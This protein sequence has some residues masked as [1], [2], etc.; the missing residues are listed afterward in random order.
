MSVRGMALARSLVAA[1]AQFD[2]Q[3]DLF[4]IPVSGLPA[5]ESELVEEVVDR[6]RS[7]GDLGMRRA[8][9]RAER[10]TSPGFSDRL[11]SYFYA[12]LVA[13]GPQ[14][15][16]QLTDAARE[17]GLVPGDARCCG[18]AFQVLLTIGADIVPGVDVPRRRGHGT[19]GG[20]LYRVAR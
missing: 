20:R 2:V 10:E 9:R 19:A 1:G 7:E 13:R 14:T 17:A 15:G 18:R 6:A 11:A 4:T 16:E 5:A 3:R 12:V 8:E